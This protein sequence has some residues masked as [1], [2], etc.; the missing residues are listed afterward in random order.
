MSRVQQRNV[1]AAFFKVVRAVAG[2]RRLFIGNALFSI[3]RV[4][5]FAVMAHSLPGIFRLRL[6]TKTRNEN[7][8][9]GIWQPETVLRARFLSMGVNRTAP[10]LR[11]YKADSQHVYLFMSFICLLLL[12]SCL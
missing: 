6:E 12:D 5:R 8:V 9:I 2:I 11:V 4:S 1:K 10:M 3:V 7:F